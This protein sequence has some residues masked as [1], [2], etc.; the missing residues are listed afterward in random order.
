MKAL[1][2]DQPGALSFTALPWRPAG[3]GEI[4]IRIAYIGYCGSD[5]N[6][7][8]GKNP[9]VKYPRVPGHEIS[10]VIETIGADVPEHFHVGQQVCVLPYFN[11]GTCN[12]CRM[13]R[14]NACKHN[15]TLGV[16]REGALTEFIAVPHGKV[17]P[18]DGLALRD[19]ALIEPLAVGFHAVRRAE[20][21]EGERVVVLGCGVI[22]LGAVLGAV[23]RGARVIAVDLAASK[24]AQAKALGAEDVIDAS[25]IDVG[26]AVRALTG[27]DGPQVVIEAVGA[28]QTFT[29]SIDI[30]ASC[31]RV[32]YVGYAKNPVTY[33][34]RFFLMKEIDIRGSRGAQLADFGDV[35]TA[36]KQ[37]PE[38]GDLVVSRVAPFSEAA[39]AMRAWDADPGAFTKI[40]IDMR[41]AV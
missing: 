28:E 13:G 3:S 36:L 7:Y 30:V 20:V 24:L 21:A 31:G 15:E 18:V 5:L 12:A 4:G 16:Q 9:L 10:G 11:C 8:R 40:L 32:V 17:I 22:G 23:T 35:I 27:D 41:G 39:D 37:R 6:S 33:E 29:Q 14:P 25:Q 1:S 38:I 19:L 26:D 34:T 2:I